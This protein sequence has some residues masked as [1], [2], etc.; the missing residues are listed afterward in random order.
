MK[1][2]AC[3]TMPCIT[4]AYLCRT[5]YKTCMGIICIKFRFTAT[6]QEE[7]QEEGVHK[8]ISHSYNVLFLRQEVSYMGVLYIIAYIW[9]FK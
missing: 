4:N 8:G 9:G 3:K 2:K 1:I 7:M 5:K 6:S